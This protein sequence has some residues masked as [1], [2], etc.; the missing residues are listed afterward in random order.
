MI[1]NNLI[2]KSRQFSLGKYYIEKITMEGTTPLNTTGMGNPQP[3]TDTTLGS[4]PMI[5]KK[6]SRKM[7]SLKDYLETCCE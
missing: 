3:P 6:K 2:Y 5:C 1:C 4:E 7:K